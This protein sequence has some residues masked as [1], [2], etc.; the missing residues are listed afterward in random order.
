VWLLKLPIH[1]FNQV[2]VTRI[3]NCIGKTIRLDLA[4]LEGARGRYVRACVEV[5]L[6]WASI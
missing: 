4:T 6:S 2:A 5:E 3:G 1:Y